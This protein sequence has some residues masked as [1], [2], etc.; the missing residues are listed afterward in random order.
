[1]VRHEARADGRESD[2]NGL[3][4]KATRRDAIRSSVSLGAFGALFTTES[5]SGADSLI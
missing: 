5:M 3:G 2:A 4:G 1:M